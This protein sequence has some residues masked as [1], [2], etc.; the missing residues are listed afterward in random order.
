MLRL[1]SEDDLIPI[2]NNRKLVRRLRGERAAIFRGYIRCLARDYAR[3]LSG[4][5][6]MAVQSATDRPDLARAI[7]RH[8]V[9]FAGAL[10]RLDA[11][12]LLYRLGIC[13]VDLSGLVESLDVLRAQTMR[14]MASSGAMAA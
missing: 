1:L 14:G 13:G 12:V 3:L 8:R 4:L 9:Y 2:K 10:F 11:M 5:S 7:L 6:L